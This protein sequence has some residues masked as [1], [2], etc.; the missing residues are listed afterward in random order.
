MCGF[1]IFGV[2]KSK[3]NFPN[4]NGRFEKRKEPE[5]IA[6]WVSGYIRCVESTFPAKIHIARDANSL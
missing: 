1:L 6:V 3:M 5:K 4:D 2:L